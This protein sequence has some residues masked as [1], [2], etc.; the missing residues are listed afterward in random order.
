MLIRLAVLNGEPKRPREASFML[1][2]RRMQQSFEI[3]AGRFTAGAR[4]R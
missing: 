2:N 3:T 4:A 1:T